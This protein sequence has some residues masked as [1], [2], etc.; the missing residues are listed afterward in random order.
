M[1]HWLMHGAWIAG[2]V[3]AGAVGMLAFYMSFLM[4]ED[5]EGVWQNRL[6]ELWI[7]I[8]EQKKAA[9]GTT[10][11][12][13]N[14][15]GDILRKAFDH[16]FGTRLLSFRSFVITAN[17]SFLTLSLFAFIDT[18]NFVLESDLRSLHIHGRSASRSRPT[19][20][21]LPGSSTLI[22]PF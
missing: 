16:L 20:L 19:C 12:L 13:F 14:R 11:A 1:P 7:I 8:D 21:Y 15:I 3:I 4:Y 22:C 10:T 6:E 5:E 18:I 9:E 17:F 2:R